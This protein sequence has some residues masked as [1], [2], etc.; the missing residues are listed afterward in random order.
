VA[1]ARVAGRRICSVW[2]SDRVHHLDVPTIRHHLRVLVPDLHGA[3]R[4]RHDR[5]LVFARFRH[6]TVPTGPHGVVAV[7]VERRGLLAL[8]IDPRAAALTTRYYNG[9]AGGHGVAAVLLARSWR[10]PPWPSLFQW[11][12]ANRL[13]AG[14]ATRPTVTDGTHPARDRGALLGVKAT[15]HVALAR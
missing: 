8:I 14:S 2:S 6:R 4:A 11:P 10:A 9:G 3:L 5:G 13:L 7:Q 15:E 12:F 1:G